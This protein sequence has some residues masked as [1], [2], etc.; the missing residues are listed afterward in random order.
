MS[1]HWRSLTS[2]G[3]LDNFFPFSVHSYKPQVS[4]FF[5]FFLRIFTNN[6][7]FCGFGCV[8]PY[9]LAGEIQYLML[10]FLIACKIPIPMKDWYTKEKFQNSYCQLPATTLNLITLIKLKCLMLKVIL[11]IFFGCSHRSVVRRLL[12]ALFLVPSFY[13]IY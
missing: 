5:V 13:I 10:S 9:F 7:P 6:L 3:S 12:E 8:Y 1:S 2:L 11:K 4:D